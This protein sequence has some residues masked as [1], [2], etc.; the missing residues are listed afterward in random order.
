MLPDENKYI[1]ILEAINLNTHTH[2]KINFFKNSNHENI[3]TTYKVLSCSDLSHAE[4]L[5]NGSGSPSLSSNQD[6]SES[7]KMDTSNNEVITSKSNVHNHTN[8]NGSA[9]PTLPPTT[10]TSSNIKRIKVE[11]PRISSRDLRS[12]R[13]SSP[14]KESEQKSRLFCDHGAKREANKL[15]LKL[16]TEL[17][18]GI[19][20][21]KKFAMEQ[22]VR[23]ALVK[24]Q[25]QQQ[26][27]QLEL[28]K[29]Q[30]A[31]LLMC[32]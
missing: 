1:I 30:Q 16:K 14:A 13:Q 28:I 10:T 25:Q 3:S 5:T 12:T 7:S 20:R 23:F 18:E 15:N 22:S 21:S 32:R 6:D 8:G 4:K 31:L 24:Q 19:K 17:E 9:D 26:K 11:I 2:T 27:Q 29:K